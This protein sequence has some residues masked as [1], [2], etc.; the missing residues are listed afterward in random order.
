MGNIPSTAHS[1]DRINNNKGY[2]KKNCRWATIN[3]QARNKRTTARILYK[4]KYRSIRDIEEELGL[5]PRVMYQRIYTYGWSVKEALSTVIQAHKYL[6][7]KR[8]SAK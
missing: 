6:P 5:N 3:Q 8:R 7:R 4:G 2:S 1:L